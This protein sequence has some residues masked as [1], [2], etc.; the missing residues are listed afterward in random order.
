[1]S[2]HPETAV[3]HRRPDPGSVVVYATTWCSFC[4][5]LLAGLRVAQIPTLVVD[6]DLDDEAAAVV[7]SVN[8]GNRT[9][10]TVLF[11]DGSTMTNPNV[12]QVGARLASSRA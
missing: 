10:P 11:P 4:A 7:E 1:M 9:V 8:G 5:R 3:G 2:D 12:A 6:I